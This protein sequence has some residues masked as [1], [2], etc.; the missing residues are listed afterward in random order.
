LQIKRDRL[1]A[2]MEELLNDYVEFEEAARKA[3]ATT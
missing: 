2:R 3:R 1:L